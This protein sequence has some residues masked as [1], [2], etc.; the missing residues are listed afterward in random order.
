MRARRL[1]SSMIDRILFDE[2]AETL[3]VWFKQSGKYTYRRVPRAIYDALARA[4]SAGTFFNES[5]RG[6]FE[7]EADPVRRR[8]PL[9]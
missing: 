6:R 3:T 2:D 8:Y 9:D 4:A 7:C 5:I 1:K